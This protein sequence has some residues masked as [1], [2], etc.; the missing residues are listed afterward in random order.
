MGK[1]RRTRQCP[2]CGSKDVLLQD[3]YDDGASLY[4]CSDCDHGFEVG[5]VRRKN[6][7]KRSNP[8]D[9]LEDV[10]LNNSWNRRIGTTDH[11]SSCSNCVVKKEH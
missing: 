2:R 7:H 6:G 3:S 10:S 9:D 5:G 11:L 4:V 1:A 8:Y